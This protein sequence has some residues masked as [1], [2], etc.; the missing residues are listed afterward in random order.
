[1]MSAWGQSWGK[2]WAASWGAVEQKALKKGGGYVDYWTD[3]KDHEPV[4]K[5]DVATIIRQV[6]GVDGVPQPAEAAL[7]TTLTDNAPLVWKDI[8]VDA[9]TKS[10]AGVTLPA[11]KVAPLDMDALDAAVSGPKYEAEILLLLSY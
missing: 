7:V 11:I 4:E 2:S 10:A 5:I 9:D 1:M 6:R 8:V 3:F